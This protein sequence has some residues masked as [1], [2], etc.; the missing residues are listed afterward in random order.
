MNILVTGAAGFIGSNLVERLLERGDRV[1]GIDSFDE[2]LYS[3][4]EKR[5]NLQ[6]VATRIRLVTG[7]I[8]DPDALASAFRERP[9]VVV[10]LAALAGVRPSLLAPE[11]YVRANVEGMTHVLETCRRSDVGRVVVASSSSVYGARSEV[12]FR[13]SDP[14]LRPISP[15]AATKRA[16]ELVAETYQHLYGLGIVNLRFFTVYGPRQRPDLA[17]RRFTELID[18]GQPIPFFGNGSTAR[19]YTWIDDI[20]RGVL[21]AIDACRAGD[22][23]RTYNLG[24]SRTTTLSRLVELLEQALGKHAVLD[25]KPAQPGDVPLTC[26]DVTLASREL[27]YAP[28]TQIEEGIPEFVSWYLRT[29]LARD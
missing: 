12:P 8:C 15:Y 9:D 22:P 7:D 10:H 18:R 27:G 2:T 28:K 29:K 24:G 19:D 23:V 20:L 26:A 14:A 3:A 25:R 16:A 4:A 5:R 17:I 21:A 6:A 13:E 11:R 1:I